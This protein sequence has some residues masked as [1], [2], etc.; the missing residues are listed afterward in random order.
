MNKESQAA[1]AAV[2]GGKGSN[3]SVKM[4]SRFG[5][6]TNYNYPILQAE[7][8]VVTHK[9]FLA[10]IAKNDPMKIDFEK[11]AQEEE[12]REHMQR[13]NSMKSKTDLQG[14]I[15]RMNQQKALVFTQKAVP[16]AKVK[17][18]ANQAD[19]G[20]KRQSVGKQ[21]TSIRQPV[22]ATG[23]QNTKTGHAQEEDAN[24][25]HSIES[26][27]EVDIDAQVEAARELLSSI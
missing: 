8:P 16:A 4:L 20:N 9:R 7:D 23:D 13:D 26:E 15:R 12:R 21:S 27:I 2:E 11:Q 5:K 3:D 1:D 18:D 10:A 19:V 25:R 6:M 24:M 14:F 22:T 17:I